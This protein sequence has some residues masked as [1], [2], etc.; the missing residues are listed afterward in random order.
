MGKKL[1]IGLGLLFH[2]MID[3]FMNVGTFVQ[4]MIAPYWVWLMGKDI[5]HLWRLIYWEAGRARRR[6]HA[7]EWL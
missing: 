1:W 4:V 6:A 7:Q 5:D 3:L 2:A